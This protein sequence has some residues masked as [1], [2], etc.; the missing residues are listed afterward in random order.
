MDT[1]TLFMTVLIAGILGGFALNNSLFNATIEV[2]AE[3]PDF[4]LVDPDGNEFSLS[5]FE[6]EKVIVLEFMNMRCGTCKNF[7]ENSL[8]SYCDDT[9]PEDVEVISITQTKNADDDE[10]TERT[11][12]MGW[13]FIKGKE[14]VTDA[15]GADRSPTVVIIDKNGMITFS[16]SGGMSQSDL[17]KEIDAALK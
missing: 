3:A 17:E 8:K 16:K 10:L 11:E 1:K 4:T 12:E 13:S 7:E 6:G 5:D 2:G 9:M 14:E 15:F